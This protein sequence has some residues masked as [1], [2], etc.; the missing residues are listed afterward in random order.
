MAEVRDAAAGGAA[1]LRLPP[2]GFWS[3]SRQDDELSDGKLSKLR[4]LLVAE[5]QQQYG[6]DP[7]QLFQDRS[8][9]PHGAEWEQ[10][11]RR[12]I[13]EATFF[14]PIV[15]PN[16]IQSEWCS[17][18]LLMFLEREQRLQESYDGVPRRSRIFPIRFIDVSGVDPHDQRVLAALEQRQGFDFTGLRYRNLQDDAVQQALGEFATSIRRA[19]HLKVRPAGTKDR[20]QA[21]TVPPAPET[22]AA[23]A[24]AVA[25]PPRQTYQAAPS[26]AA[27]AQAAASPVPGDG[28]RTA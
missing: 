14:I 28:R 25:E 18:E 23:A 6:R 17:A 21:A 10:E 27:S 5:I 20:A 24:A 7:V 8:T 11:I 2:V 16:F 4:R 26:V 3:Y 9:I 15:T 12:S 22:V 1:A 13:D 19:L